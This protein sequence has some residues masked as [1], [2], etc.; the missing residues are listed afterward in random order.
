LINNLSGNIE[1]PRS[2]LEGIF[3]PQ[4]VFLFFM[5]ANP[6]ASHGECARGDSKLANMDFSFLRN[7]YFVKKYLLLSFV[8]LNFFLWFTAL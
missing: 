8:F 6:A 2:K 4:L 3:D 1:A 7:L 5:L